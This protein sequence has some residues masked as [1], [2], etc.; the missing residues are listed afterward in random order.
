MVSEN[1]NVEKELSEEEIR[2]L[3]TAMKTVNC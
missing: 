1:A 2:E 3:R